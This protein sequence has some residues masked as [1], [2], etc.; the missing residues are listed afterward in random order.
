VSAIL[1][2]ATVAAGLSIASE[3]PAQADPLG[4]LS[5]FAPY[6][7]Y[8]K[9]GYDLY[10]KYL[11]GGG[12]DT[13]TQIETA[14]HVAETEIL[15][16]IDSIATDEVRTCADTAINSYHN[17]ATMERAVVQQ[18]AIDSSTCVFRARN[19]I[20]DEDTLSSVD[21]LG[22]ALNAVGPISLALNAYAGFPADGVRN[23]LIGANNTLQTRLAPQCVVWPS[24]HDP[25]NGDG[26]AIIGRGTCFAYYRAMPRRPTYVVG[27]G[28]LGVVNPDVGTGVASVPW[29]VHGYWHEETTTWPFTHDVERF[30]AVSDYSQAISE[31]MAYSSWEVAGQ[32]LEHL[33]PDYNPPGN[34]VALAESS[35]PGST[36]DVI[37]TNA[38]DQVFRSTITTNPNGFSGWGWDGDNDHMRSVAAASDADGRI[39]EFTVTRTGKIMHRWQQAAHDNTSWTSWATME[40]QLNSITVARGSD[41]LL[42]LFGTN[43]LGQVWTNIQ[44][45]NA[46]YHSLVTPNPS[47]PPVDAWAGWR[48]LGSFGLTKVAAVTSSDGRMEVWGLSS[49]GAIS[50][51]RQASLLTNG[52]NAPVRVEG[53]LTDI[54]ASQ[55]SWG[56]PN[57]VGA[58]SDGQVF[59]AIEETSGVQPWGIVMAPPMRHVALSRDNTN[60]KG[61]VMVGV[62]TDGRVWVTRNPGS[63]QPTPWTSW[64]ELG[65]LLR[66]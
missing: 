30:P 13:L 60:L 63:L 55:D 61:L 15:A 43:A 4:Q 2:L 45:L 6:V 23:A 38:A 9:K 28:Y 65:G 35:Q 57:I 31:A 56:R 10:N 49:T 22:F 20:E 39:E 29:V 42:Q 52:W 62:G 37:G 8:V 32:A 40:G 64:T 26:R 41:G 27:S 47:K 33:L 50:Y 48:L 36:V 5:Q 18:L 17:L 1:A 14:I 12:L 46:D 66:P 51:M 19:L 53:T 25:Q 58:N 11:A 34:S 7:E 44:V 16:E 21:Q 59:R 54:A 24:S 3:K